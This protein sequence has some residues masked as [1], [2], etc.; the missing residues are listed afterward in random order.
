M[1]MRETTGPS[2]FDALFTKSVP[3]I[4]E[5][6]F[7]SLDYESFNRCVN[8]SKSWKA[9]ITSERFQRMGKSIFQEEIKRNESELLKA[10][11]DGS[12]REVKRILGNFMVDVDCLREYI[13]GTPLFQAAIKDHKNVV[14]FLLDRGADPNKADNYGQTPLHYAAL[15]GHKDV[16]KLLL[17][18]G[19]QPNMYFLGNTPLHEAACN[20]YKDVVELL[21]DRGAESNKRAGIDGFTP[22][23]LAARYGHK[24]V[25]EHLLDR[26]A[27]PDRVTRD[28]KTPLHEACR[29]G[30]KD[31]VWLLLA[32][33]A[34][35]NTTDEDGE[36]PLATALTRG[37]RA[38][39]RILQGES[40]YWDLL[41][42]SVLF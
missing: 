32:R 26:R 36:T 9:L 22:L 34:N 13:R 8:V 6:I 25:V 1:D 7:F 23:H 12:L 21:L 4:L 2:G 17:D 38:I 18:R 39:A 24:N 37:H 11:W 19:A 29:E 31:V 15:R 41:S 3:H 30:Y 16:V 28:G 35:P 33:G 27:E 14:Q 40:T 10:S 5:K 42:L 20:G